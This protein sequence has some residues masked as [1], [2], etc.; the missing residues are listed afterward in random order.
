MP[1]KIAES[2][3]GNRK[4]KVLSTQII[5]NYS[6][7]LQPYLAD[8]TVHPSRDLSQVGV[9][10]AH[11]G[12]VVLATQYLLSKSRAFLFLFPVFIIINNLQLL[13]RP[14]HSTLYE[15][16]FVSILRHTPNVLLHAFCSNIKQ[17]SHWPTHFYCAT[18]C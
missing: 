9:A 6:Y 14:L 10:C 18:L 7:L 1:K 15:L 3:N 13:Q 16:R 11:T 4:W 12:S 2:V 8:G 17:C 5:K